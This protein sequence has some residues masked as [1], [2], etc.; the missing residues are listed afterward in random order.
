MGDDDDDEYSLLH[1]GG[2]S[3]S[4]AATGQS[5]N[6]DQDQREEVNTATEKHSDHSHAGH[7][8]AEEEKVED[9]EEVDEAAE[10][11][12]ND[13]EI[14]E[15]AD[16]EEVYDEDEIA[17]YPQGTCVEVSVTYEGESE[18]VWLPAI[19]ESAP[20]SSADHSADEH[21]SVYVLR[22]LADPNEDQQEMDVH[23]DFLRPV[24]SDLPGG[25]EVGSPLVGEAVE[26]GTPAQCWYAHENA[27]FACQVA[28][29]NRDAGVAVV[30]FIDFDFEQEVS[31]KSVY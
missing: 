2:A 1:G 6:R 4:T 7:A 28:E 17:Y 26:V 23:A 18:E 12:G 29:V 15:E 20:E 5:A 14:V 3:Q 8:A 31:L 25:N 22:L 13:E 11:G 30:Q 10:E 21:G 16:E 27:F 9:E 19:V 24:S